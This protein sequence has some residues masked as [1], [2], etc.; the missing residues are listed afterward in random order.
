M[1]KTPSWW[2][3]LNFGAAGH[4]GSHPVRLIDAL[5]RTAKTQNAEEDKADQTGEANLPALDEEGAGARQMAMSK[6]QL[7][8]KPPGA[9]QDQ[10]EPAG[11]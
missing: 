7:A 8:G 6:V 4:I 10:E 11:Q 9:S 5:R 1:L 3:N 2:V